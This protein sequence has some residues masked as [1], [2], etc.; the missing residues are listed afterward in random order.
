M[1]KSAD[2]RS[3]VA[4][5]SARSNVID[6][7][8]AKSHVSRHVAKSL[9]PVVIRVWHPVTSLN[10]AKKRSRVPTRSSLLAS[11]RGLSKR[12]NAMLRA[13]EMATRRRCSDATKS[14]QG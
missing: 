9:A 2:V 11:A 3:S 14:A 1:A 10:P 12:P 8:S 7:D 6:P 4:H 5:T 13:T